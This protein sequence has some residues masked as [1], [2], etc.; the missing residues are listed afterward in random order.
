MRAERGARRARQIRRSS[1]VTTPQQLNVVVEVRRT[2]L[3]G[4]QLTLCLLV[5][6]GCTQ[7]EVDWPVPRHMTALVDAII[8]IVFE[9][10]FVIA[11]YDCVV[12]TLD[13]RRRHRYH[14]SADRHVDSTTGGVVRDV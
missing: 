2:V 3:H 10:A 1:A 9:A 11:M 7:A 4:R 8:L 6:D 12:L 5:A 13:L 14:A